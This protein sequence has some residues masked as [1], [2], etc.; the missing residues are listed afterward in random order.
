M[1]VLPLAGEFLKRRMFVL[2]FLIIF[3]ALKTVPSTNKHSVNV[4]CSSFHRNE[5]N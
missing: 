3:K 2:I 5:E 1:S 4:F